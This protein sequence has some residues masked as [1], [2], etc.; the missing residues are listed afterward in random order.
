MKWSSYIKV[1]KKQ[2][3]FILSFSL[4]ELAYPPSHYCPMLSFEKESSFEKYSYT[5]IS[6]LN[7]SYCIFL[8][9]PSRLE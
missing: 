2:L 3:L 8:R 6:N 4:F 1:L 9:L 5:I 7:S